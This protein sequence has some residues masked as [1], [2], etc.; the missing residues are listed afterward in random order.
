MKS[1]NDSIVVIE[2][3]TYSELEA[4]VLAKNDVLMKQ[5]NNAEVPIELASVMV[6]GFYKLA[7]AVASH[8][9]DYEK[10]L[11]LQDMYIEMCKYTDD[12]HLN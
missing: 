11:I 12:I 7:N 5:Y 1:M 2:Y 4:R 3:P 10:I 6:D 8:K 9:S